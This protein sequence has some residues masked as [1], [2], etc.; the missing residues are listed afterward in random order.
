MALTTAAV[1]FNRI[2]DERTDSAL[3]GRGAIGRIRHGRSG[4]ASCRHPAADHVGRRYRRRAHMARANPTV[5]GRS[6][7]DQPG[8]A[9]LFG[10]AGLHQP[11]VVRGRRPNTAGWCRR[12][13]T[14]PCTCPARGGCTRTGDLAARCRHPAHRDARTRRA[15]NRGEP[16]DAPEQV[17]RR[18]SSRHRRAGRSRSLGVEGKAKLSQNRSEADRR[19]VVAGLR[20][21]KA[22]MGH[23][24]VDA[25]VG[26][27][28]LAQYT[29]RT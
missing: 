3:R 23:A 19:G 16:S 15:P 4:R 25:R 18:T 7:A 9:D 10:T 17:H 1:T 22:L 11:V 20:R 28:T 29:S 5:E 6:P 24:E 26:A 27:R 12:G 8:A 2:D 14:A 21:R 13:T